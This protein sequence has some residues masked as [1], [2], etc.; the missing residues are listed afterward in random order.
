[1]STWLR[2]STPW[3]PRA[4]FESL[5][6]NVE[7]LRHTISI[8]ARDPVCRRR[9]CRGPRTFTEA[10][11]RIRSGK[12]LYQVLEG[13]VDLDQDTLFHTAIDLPANL[14][15]GDYTARILL[16]RGGAVVDEFETDIPVNKV[17]LERWLYQPGA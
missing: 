1:M 9:G 15:E 10:L 8:P 6:S 2:P 3:R 11:I 7:D 14:T 4:L 12:E 16:T 13:A 5:L 17:G